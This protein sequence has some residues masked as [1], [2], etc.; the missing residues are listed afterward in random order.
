MGRWNSSTNLVG[1]YY[2]GIDA[3]TSMLALGMVD[4][5]GQASAAWWY[6]LSLYSTDY[7][8]ADQAMRFINWW[9]GHEVIG[10]IF[11]AIIVEEVPFHSKNSNARD[12]INRVAMAAGGALA[13]WFPYEYIHRTNNWAWKNKVLKSGGVSKDQIDAWWLERSPQLA[14]L[15]KDAPQDV[16]DGFTLGEYG[17]LKY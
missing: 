14:E 17:R 16:F 9:A 4:S 11:G 2:L 15:P 5:K 13:S 6:K 12:K 7:G 1:P 8:A 10:I 3:K